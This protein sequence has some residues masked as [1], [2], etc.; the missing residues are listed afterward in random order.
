MPDSL[1][2]EGGGFFLGCFFRFFFAFFLTSFFHRFFFDFGRVLEVKWRPKIDFWGAF[3]DGFLG[4]SFWSDF[5]MHFDD[6]FNAQLL[7]NS[8]FT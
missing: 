2:S 8:D 7:E 5:L 4:P 6:L 3:W 1:G